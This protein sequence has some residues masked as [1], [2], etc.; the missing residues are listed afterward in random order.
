M[1]TPAEQ[2]RKQLARQRAAKGREAALAAAVSLLSKHLG[3]RLL[4]ELVALLVRVDPMKLRAAL[5][6][7]VADMPEPP[8]ISDAEFRELPVRE[9]WLALTPRPAM[10]R[11]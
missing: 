1:Q 7:K 3:D 8:P 4:H 10:K 11:A 9:Q 5:I 6:A 2:R